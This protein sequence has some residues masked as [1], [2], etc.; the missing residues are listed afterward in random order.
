[1]PTSR[2]E[3]IRM[4]SARRRSLNERGI[5]IL[6]AFSSLRALKTLKRTLTLRH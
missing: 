4:N 3:V 2:R 1:M 5:M 6:Q